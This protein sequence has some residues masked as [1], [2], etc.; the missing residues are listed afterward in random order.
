MSMEEYLSIEAGYHI[1][2][3]IRGEPDKN[4]FMKKYKEVTMATLEELIDMS[5]DFDEILDDYVKKEPPMEKGDKFHLYTTGV[6]AD[7]E[8]R[9]GKAYKGYGVT[10]P[11]I[12]GSRRSGLSKNRIQAIYLRLMWHKLSCGR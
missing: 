5:K 12:P 11:M 4:G 2:R 3:A 10:M 9:P 6:L 1:I 8:Q 7:A